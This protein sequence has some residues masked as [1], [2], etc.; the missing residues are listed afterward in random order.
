MA[1]ADAPAQRGTQ[2]RRGLVL[3]ETAPGIPVEAVRAATATD[4]LVP[5]SVP[6]MDLGFLGIGGEHATSD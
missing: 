4:L 2:P 5:A 1:V 6:E 3:R